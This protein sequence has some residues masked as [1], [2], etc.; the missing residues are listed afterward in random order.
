MG[1][2][3][4]QRGRGG[5]TSGGSGCTMR[6]GQGHE[7]E[8]WSYK[9]EGTGTQV[10]GVVIQGGRGRDTGGGSGHTRSKGRGHEWGS[11]RP[12]TPLHHTAQGGREAQG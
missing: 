1:G 5:D 8:E 11:G 12:I 3:V 10:G 7:W 9:E 6:K 4:V 2:V